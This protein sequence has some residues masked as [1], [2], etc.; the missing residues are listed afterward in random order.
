MIANL[1]V[2]QIIAG[3]KTYQEV[4]R[5]LKERVRAILIEKNRE[6]LLEEQEEE[7]NE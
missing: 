4:P 5:L 2:E 7:L 6:D 3:N 1:W